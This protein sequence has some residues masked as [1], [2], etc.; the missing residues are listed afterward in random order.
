MGEPKLIDSANIAAE[1]IRRIAS[2]AIE[3]LRKDIKNIHADMSLINERLDA[4]AAVIDRNAKGQFVDAVGK[5]ENKPLQFS[6]T[7]NG[8]SWE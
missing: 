2:E 4:L 1:T 6:W 5:K 8:R 7:T 3:P